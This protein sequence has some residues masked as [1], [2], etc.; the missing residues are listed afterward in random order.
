MEKFIHV[1]LMDISPGVKV[2]IEQKGSVH[3][4]DEKE[5]QSGGEML[6]PYEQGKRYNDN[7]PFKKRHV[8]SL[9]AISHQFKFIYSFLGTDPVC[10]ISGECSISIVHFFL[11][12][13]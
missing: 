11:Y 6:T 2:L 3:S 5:P 7:L 4:L 13:F 12:P 10:Q 1:T 8:G 9:Q